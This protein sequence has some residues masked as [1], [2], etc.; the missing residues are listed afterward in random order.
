[1]NI[2]K[3]FFKWLTGQSFNLYM[4]GG[5]SGGGGSTQSTNTSYQTSIPEYAK[6]YVETMLGAT[7][8]QLFQGTPTGEGGF[9]ITGFQPYKAYGGTYDAQGN[10]TSYDPT[11]GIAGFQPMQQQAFSNAANMGVAPQ[12]NQAS[13]LAGSAGIA[14]LNT[15]YDPSNFYANQVQAPDLQ[16]YQ[17]QGP[18]NVYAPRTNVAQLGAAPQADA[19]QF[20]GP[21]AIGYDAVQSQN[22]NT[23]MMGAAQTGYDPQLQT[24]QMQGP[25]NIRSQ[26]FNQNS[27]QQYMN[28]YAQ[29]VIAN[30]QRD[31]QRQADIAGT[32]RGAR[33][34]QAGAFGGSRQAIENAEAAR[35]L[36]LQKGDIEATGMQNAYS[37]AQQQFNADQARQL[38]AQQSNQQA[39][40]QTGTQNLSAALGVQQLG[41]QTGLQTSLANLSS[42]QQ[43]NV[44]NQAAQLQTQGM[45]SQ[46]A[47]QAALANQQAGIN[48]GQFNATNAYNTGLQNAQMRQQAGLSNQAMQGQ[49]GLQQGQFRQGAN[50]QNA[51]QA[52]QA[53]L[54]NQQTGYNVGAQNLQSMLGTQQLGAGQ[55]LQSQLAN[56]QAGM[57]AQQATEASRQYGAG[58]GMQGLQTGLSAAGQ[59]GQLGQNAYG[60]QMGITQLQ[61]QYGAQQQA[62]QQQALN[63]AIQDY[64]NAQQYPLMQLGTMSNMLR[65][66]PMQAQTTQQYAAAPNPIT[67]AIGAAGAGAS[68][69]NAFKAKGGV[70]KE[71]A[72]G[73]ILSYDVGGEIESDLSNMDESGL[74]R[75]L[76]ESSSPSVKRM[77]QRILRERQLEKQPQRPSY[78]GGGIIAFAEGDKVEEPTASELLQQRVMQGKPTGDIVPQPLGIA[79]AAQAAPPPAPKPPLTSLQAAQAD[80]DIPD[81]MKGQISDLQTRADRSIPDIMKEK[82]AA[83]EA[84]GVAQRDPEA[85]ANLMKERANAED[86][87]KRNRYLQAAAFFARWGS[88]PGSTLAAGLTA[89]RDRVPDIVEG[90]KEA[91]KIRMEINKSIASLDE[92]TRLETIGKID[93]AAAVKEKDAEKMQTLFFKLSDIEMQ[94]KKEAAAQKK[95]ETQEALKDKREEAKDTRYAKLHTD[96]TQMKIDADKEN[97]KILA[98]Y[99]AAD[100]AEANTD[101]LLSIYRSAQD[102]KGTAEQR[103]G[104]IM[105]TEEYQRALADSST[106]IDANT[107]DASKRLQA[108]AAQALKEF[109][110]SF[111]TMRDTADKTVSIMEERLRAKKVDIPSTKK[112]GDRPSLDDP[113]LQ[114]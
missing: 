90:E 92:A 24:Y 75:Q 65:G 33:A 114:K 55:N 108:N 19:A 41:A 27:A 16:N 84:A 62:Q 59:L 53:S 67:Q 66:L 72:K 104:N 50:T 58:L 52:L 111:T 61:G 87:A 7:Q 48:T 25:Q 29:S 70:I 100:K 82:Q 107:S 45:N 32:Q 17:M 44:Q 9:D 97:N 1:M 20:N 77:A 18:G 68:L 47:M 81:V 95:M 31:A 83:Y 89:V 5:G 10:Q 43:A 103:I 28:P 69:Y 109:K 105:K 46:Q 91:K 35:N 4:G 38:T 76:K 112:S 71:Y 113:K 6:P 64:S 57:T 96:I 40:L 80:P 86:E 14:A 94:N 36:A 2:A 101:R 78:A 12:L 22:Q 63:Q 73:G 42:E 79:Q 102:A 51:Q 54:A 110:D 74:Q 8:K 23:P 60:Q 30:Q 15:Q 88:T 99:R 3:H 49:Y 13:N 39:G 98:G 85:R 26:Q 106:P 93:A 11:K 34:A 37:Q 21:G 56:Q